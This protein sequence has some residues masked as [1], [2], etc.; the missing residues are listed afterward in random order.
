M[1]LFVTKA[2]RFTEKHTDYT[3][4]DPSLNDISTSCS[5]RGPGQGLSLAD[6]GRAILLF[7]DS[8]MCLPMHLRM[9]RVFA[10]ACCL[11]STTLEVALGDDEVRALK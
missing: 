11:T 10:H 7:L 6:W 2:T 4:E 8:L 5:Q 3:Y 1:S 9:R